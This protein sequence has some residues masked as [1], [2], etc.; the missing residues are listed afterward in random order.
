MEIIAAILSPVLWLLG[1]VVA[2]V[3]AIVSYLLWAV[4]WLL[5]PFALI[6]FV[7]LRVTEKLLG[8]DLV[9]AWVKKQSLKFGAGTWIKARRLT[10][11]LGALPLRVVGWGI[12]YTL[13]HSLISLFVKPRWSPWQRAW[14]KRWKP[15]QSQSRAKSAKIAKAR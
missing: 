9:R 3:W 12:V 6:A 14:D 7:A 13:W 10:F 5:L 1:W 11:A 8:P 4:L 2:I 15:P